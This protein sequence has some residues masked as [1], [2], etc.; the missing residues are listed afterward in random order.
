MLQT[1][2]AFTSEKTLCIANLLQI[3]RPLFYLHIILAITPGSLLII[4]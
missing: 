1:I 2:L 3:K 4:P